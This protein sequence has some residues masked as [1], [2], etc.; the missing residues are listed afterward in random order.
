MVL[1][2]HVLAATDLSPTSLHA[3]DRAFDIARATG[4]RLTLMSALGLDA[5]GPLRDL[6]GMQAEG[7]AGALVDQQRRSLQAI[8]ADPAR[9]KGR[10]AD[11]QIQVEEG[12]AARAIPA[13]AARSDADL[14]VIGSRGQGALRRFLIGSTASHLLRKN[15]CPVLVVKRAFRAAYRRV[16]LAVD[17][18]A[19]SEPAI[20]AGRAVA[21]TADLSLLNV[22]DVPFEG[23]L[24][25]AG[26]T[27]DIISHYRAEARQKA[28]A[29][30]HAQAARA[31]LE[32]GTFSVHVQHG[33]STESI[34]KL[35]ERERCDLIVMGKH[36]THV[37]EELLLG[38]V[39]KRVL[40]ESKADLL[41]VIDKQP[42]LP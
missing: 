3:V 24:S 37:T 20:R 19:A 8:A 12:L 9:S 32:P 26:V 41:V 29:G 22:F 13:Y 25:F 17:F 7:V 21:P 36:G 14:V 6:L 38:S 10:T 33:D 15:H 40:D 31:G 35:A 11:V 28:L 1:I 4:A 16:L 39:T 2:K 18:S 5:L 30:L 42:A 23:M 27:E 34:L